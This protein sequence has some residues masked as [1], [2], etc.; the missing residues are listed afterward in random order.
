MA[1]KM[2]EITAATLPDGELADLSTGADYWTTRACPAIGLT[3]IRLADGPHGLRVQDDNNADHLGLERSLPATCF[4]PAV[5]L[6]SSWD[7]ELVEEVGAAL[8]LEA[9]SQGVQ[10]ILGPGLNLKR[11][12][13]C[14]RNFE[15]Y[16][17]DPWLSGRLAG[18]MVRGIQSR[19]VAAVLKHF[20]LNNQETDRLRVSAE[21]DER[22]M[23]EIYLRTFEIAIREGSPWGIMSAY[24]RI[25]GIYASENHWLLT[26]ILR[27]EWGFD[28]VVVSDWGAVQDPVK[29]IAAGLDLRM[30]GAASAPQVAQALE[31]GTLPRQAVEQSAVRLRQLAERTGSGAGPLEIDADAHHQLVRRAAAQSAVLLH[32]GAGLLPLDDKFRGSIAVIGEL[33]RTPRY[34]GAG[35]SAVNP[36]RVTC[37][38]D[39]LQ[40][41]FAGRISFLP[42]YSLDADS[43]EELIAPA[44]ALAAASDRVLLFLGLPPA[45]ET[46]G[47]D[48]SNIDLPAAHI[49]L[50]RAIARVNP[51]VIVVLCN[52]SAVTTAQWRRDAG[53]IVEFWL[54]GQAHGEAIADIL[55][56]DV[57]P[58]GKLAETIP[59]RLEDTPAY[60]DFPGE[61]GEVRYSEGVFVGYRWY[62]ARRMEVDYPFGHGLSYTRFEYSD[63]AVEVHPLGDPVAL[64]VSLTLANAGSRDGAEVAQVYIGDRTG[65]LL[66]PERELRAFCKVTIAA[67]SRAEVRMPIARKDLEHFHRTAGW[68]FPGGKVTIC[69]GA[70]SRDVRLMTEVELPGKKIEIPLTLH[71]T[72]GEWLSHERVGPRLRALFDSRGGVKGRI[73][74]LLNDAIGSASVLGFPFATIIQFPGV[75]VSEEEA[76]GMLQFA[77]SAKPQDGQP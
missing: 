34:Q 39:V 46:E 45:Y 69:V 22:T 73:G 35:S 56:G 67:G 44:M 19:G 74:D 23:R 33:A 11:T 26:D 55:T 64:T 18:A 27:K 9:R 10:V 41:R 52:G 59:L 43:A 30:P 12:P 3:T 2:P 38:L 47:R 13:L 14:G 77:Q 58:S 21:V 68:V 50:L 25:N 66:M 48:R 36:R 51:R 32:N 5:T 63:L 61:L 76:V 24:N 37:A 17:E 54:T 53:A 28:G 15:Y 40:E 31:V 4:P 8:A 72:L 16:S 1:S 29:A 57:N 6:A 60:L 49:K 62:D 65:I 70:S 20:A 7:P 42:G 71:S 75:P